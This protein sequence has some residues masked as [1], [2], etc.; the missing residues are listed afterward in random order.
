MTK[1][2]YTARRREQRNNLW[3]ARFDFGVFAVLV[4][5]ALWQIGTPFGGAA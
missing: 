3:K 1:Q 4:L 5:M 2:E